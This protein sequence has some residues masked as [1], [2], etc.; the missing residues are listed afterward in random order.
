[1]LVPISESETISGKDGAVVVDEDRLNSEQLRDLACVLAARPSEARQTGDRINRR[2]DRARTRTYICFD[3]AYP[4][5]S[6][7]AR[8]GLAIVSF[9]TLMKLKDICELQE[10]EGTLQGVPIDNLVHAHLLL[11]TDARIDVL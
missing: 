9:A 4:R 10:T 8:M 1:M 5:A 11:F 7:S 2:E 6:V 3:V